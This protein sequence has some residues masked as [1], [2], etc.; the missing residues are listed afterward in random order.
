MLLVSV[1]YWCGVGTGVGCG[2]VR[3]CYWCGVGT[4]E[5]VCYWCG[6]GTGVGCATGE[7]WGLVWGGD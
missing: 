7:G 6:V 2:L 3:V 1:C 5:C 4:G